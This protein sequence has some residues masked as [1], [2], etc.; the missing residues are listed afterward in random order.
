[1][2]SGT[3]DLVRLVAG[4]WHIRRKMRL[5][6]R[7][8]KVFPGTCLWS[9]QTNPTVHRC[10]MSKSP[11]WAMRISSR[12]QRPKHLTVS[13]VP[14]LFPKPLHDRSR[15]PMTACLVPVPIW[16]SCGRSCASCSCESAAGAALTELKLFRGTDIVP[17]KQRRNSLAVT[18][19]HQNTQSSAN[20]ASPLLA[21]CLA[22]VTTAHQEGIGDRAPTISWRLWTWELSPTDFN[23]S[24]HGDLAPLHGIRPFAH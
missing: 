14:P 10:H 8:V 3:H 18:D 9:I 13:P 16:K 22:Q 20:P 17:C 2:Y 5:R 23:L 24:Q 12:W 4:R 19:F 21:R 1:M 11:I 15:A 7:R 6:G